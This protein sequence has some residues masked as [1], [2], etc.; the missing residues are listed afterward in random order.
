[1][2]RMPTDYLLRGEYV[3][4]GLDDE[5]PT[6]S[7]I[8]HL[9]TECVDPFTEPFPYIGKPSVSISFSI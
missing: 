1:M 3:S 7:Y 5:I 4:N 2:N 8:G 9:T 6:V